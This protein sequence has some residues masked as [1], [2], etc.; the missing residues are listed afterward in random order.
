VSVLNN[1]ILVAIGVALTLASLWYGQHHGLL[2]ATAAQ[3]ASLFD[4]LF[5]TTMVIATGIFLIVQGLLIYSAIQ[6]RKRKG[7]EAD[8]PP[9]HGNVLLEIVWT[10]VP[11][12]IILWL[13][14]A[15]LDVYQAIGG[16]LDPGGHAHM[17]MT[18]TASKQTNISASG[19]TPALAIPQT[20]PQSVDLIVQVSAM[21]Y[22]WVFTYLESGVVAGELHVPTD[23]RVR[24]EMTAQD[25]LH[26]FWVPQF[27]LKQDVIPGRD[28]YLEFTPTLAG[29]YAIICAELCGPYHGAMQAQLIVESFEDF[30]AWQQSQV[31][32]SREISEK[33]LAMGTVPQQQ[34]STFAAAQ[35]HRM[36]ISHLSGLMDPHSA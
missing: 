1:I 30:Q 6:F 3:E 32:A 20:E 33:A 36:G 16:G 7:D 31:V 15:S 29:E 35:L 28:T 9:V 25:V 11:A 18:P 8:G 34:P 14:V 12:V 22:A 23:R 21:Q 2:P 17:A 10:A 4:G 13:A 5:N 19:Y 26:A 24:L 27:R